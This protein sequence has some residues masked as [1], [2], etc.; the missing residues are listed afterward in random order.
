MSLRNKMPE[1]TEKGC[2]LNPSI[3]RTL[4]FG[5]TFTPQ[6]LTE[7]SHPSHLI[8]YIPPNTI[9][10]LKNDENS[11][12]RHIDL[13]ALSQDQSM[14]SYI[15]ILTKDLN[16]KMNIVAINIL[17]KLNDKALALLL[18][19]I[20]NCSKPVSTILITHQISAQHASNYRHPN[21]P[22][23]FAHKFILS[24][25]A[26]R[27]DFRIIAQQTDEQQFTF[28]VQKLH[29]MHHVNASKNKYI[30]SYNEFSSVHEGFINNETWAMAL[31]KT[32]TLLN[33]PIVKSHLLSNNDLVIQ[34]GI[35]IGEC[36]DSHRNVIGY[37]YS[38][39][40]IEY[41]NKNKPFIKTRFQDLN[42]LNKEKTKLQ[43]D[44]QLKKDL[45]VK[46]NIFL[47]NIL[48]FLT[49]D[50]IRLLML[51]IIDYAQTGSVC[52][53]KFWS[54]SKDNNNGHD[55]RQQ[56][57]SRDLNPRYFLDL[58]TTHKNKIEYLD[59]E[60]SKKLR[61]KNDEQIIENVSVIVVKKI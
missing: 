37:E 48:E 35:G 53:L 51:A 1:I 29:N 40:A 55:L 49:D 43:Y 6:T 21:N 28:A 52:V 8:S 7:I 54:L 12:V 27:T 4:Q 56:N 61:N 36:F 33:V 9:T 17:G 23:A 18:H 26:V 47:I 58:F 57:N 34:F 3:P 44:A 45:K 24:F 59:G 30:E 32:K 22:E 39:P 16:V 20:I 2:G 15:D 38:Q 60:T 13:N 11:I 41:L 19:A 5:N 42:A 25:F 46:A 31:L 14:L 10:D 50:A